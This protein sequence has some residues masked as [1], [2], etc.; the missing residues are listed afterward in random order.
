VHH[1]I[2]KVKKEN[3]FDKT[4]YLL[5]LDFI[6]LYPQ[7]ISL[8]NIQCLPFFPSL[9]LQLLLTVLKSI[10]CQIPRIHS[11][12]SLI[13]KL[14][15]L[16]KYFKRCSKKGIWT[17]GIPYHLK[18]RDSFCVME[19]SLPR[20]AGLLRVLKGRHIQMLSYF[21]AAS[22]SEVFLKWPIH[23]LFTLFNSFYFSLG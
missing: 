5:N 23:S 10:A 1:C 16:I 7:G 3:A 17:V 13:R 9:L 21:N 22:Q 4:S 2:R 14:S 18:A 12:H 8:Q 11:C 19:S 20:S 15:H 6:N